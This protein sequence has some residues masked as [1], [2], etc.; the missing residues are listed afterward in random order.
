MLCQCWPW[1]TQDWSNVADG[2]DGGDGVDSEVEGNYGI[3][4]GG[5]RFGVM[6]ANGALVY[7]P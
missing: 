1:K 3:V 2:G 7:C 5:R 6:K 4:R